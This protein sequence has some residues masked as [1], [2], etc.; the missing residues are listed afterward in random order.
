VDDDFYRG[1][2]NNACAEA[3]R[4]VRLMP[5]DRAAA[6]RYSR[7]LKRLRKSIRVFV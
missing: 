7:S 1:A 4:I 2:G 6:G 3:N 5:T